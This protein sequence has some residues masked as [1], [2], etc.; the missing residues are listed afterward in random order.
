MPPVK[1]PQQTER[2]PYPAYNFKVSVTNV[3]TGETVSGSFSEVSGLSVEVQ[4]IEYR[5]GNAED[6]VVKVRGL[7]KVSNITLKRGISG[8]VGF[9]RWLQAGIDG[10]VDRQEGYIA[11]LNEDRVEVMRWTFKEAWPTKGTGPSLNAKTN[12][13]A[14]ETLDLV[15]RDLR[16]SLQ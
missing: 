16:I 2:Y 13:I 11:L 4:P 8:H 14:L 15:V 9:W 7:R 1:R 5:E 12:E 6:E 3:D 10:D